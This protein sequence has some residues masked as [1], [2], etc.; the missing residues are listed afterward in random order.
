MAEACPRCGSEFL[1]NS[2][3]CHS[4]GGR[5]PIA[6]SPADKSDAAFVADLWKQ[7]VEGV[8]SLFRKLSLSHLKPPPW[9]HYLHFH[10]IKTR[11]GLSTGS[12]ISFVI[13]LVCVVGALTVGFSTV[14][15]V[16]EWQAIQYYRA[17]W[18]LAATAA[19]VAGI[20]LKKT[21]DQD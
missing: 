21:I 8:Q 7:I 17:E 1:L 15:T 14:K 11:T 9:L 16:V 6:V 2:K 20:L 19:F 18:L 3:F 12:L 13:G 5:R 4:C 10:E